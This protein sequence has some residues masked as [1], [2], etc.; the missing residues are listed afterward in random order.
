MA[1][2][3]QTLTTFQTRVRQMILRFQELKKENEELYAMVDQNEKDI[4]RLR[5]DLENRSSD[6]DSLKMAKMM[7]IT[8][9]DLE[10][11]KNRLA[12]LIRDVNKCIAVLTEQK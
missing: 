1:P 11:A 10:T 9:G 2:N 3:E 5:A 4:R 8:D 6:Y 7:E 12:K